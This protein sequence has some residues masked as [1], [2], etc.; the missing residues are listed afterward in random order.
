MLIARAARE[1][2]RLSR[3]DDRTANAPPQMRIDADG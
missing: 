1:E 2:R 3:P